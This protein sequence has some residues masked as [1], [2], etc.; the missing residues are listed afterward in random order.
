VRR[1]PGWRRS[2]GARTISGPLA[3][4]PRA[5]RAR[6][7]LLAAGLGAALFLLAAR[8][9]HLQ[10]VRAGDLG[11]LARSQQ[12]RTITLDPRRAPILDRNGKELALSVDVDSIFADPAEVADPATAARRL[13]PVLGLKPAELRERLGGDRHFVWIKRKVGPDLRRRVEALRIEGIGFVKE[14]RRF[15]PKRGLA[16]HVLGACGLDN[17]GLAGL[18]FAYDGAIQGTP[19]R[20][21]FLRDGRGGR[22]LDRSRTEPTPGTGLVLTIDEVLQHLAERELDAAMESFRPAGA[23]IVVLRPQSGEILALANR[24]TFDPNDFSSAREEARRD[25]AVTDYYEPGSTFKVITASAALDAKRVRPDETIWCENGS[26]VVARHRFKEDRVPYGNLTVTEVLAKS[27][28]VGAIKIASRLR[29]SE[30]LATIRAFGFGHK[31]GVELPGE[32]GGMLR[33]LDDWSGLSQ[34]SIAMG[35]E[36]GATPLQLAAALGALANDGVYVRPR[37]VG[38]T[39]APD[40][41]RIPALSA[42]PGETRRVIEESTARTLRRMLQ[43]VTVDGTGRAA[44]VPGYSVGGKTG[45]AQKIEGG[46]YSHQK[47][48]SWF[49]G[50]VPADRPALTIV[51]MVDEP[52]GPKFHGGDVA[53][54]VFSRV[55][56][57]ALEYLGVP[58]DVER[59]LVPDPPVVRAAF[60]PEQEVRAAG[61]TGRPSFTALAVLPAVVQPDPDGAAPG[62]DDDAMP[63]LRGLSLRQASE[64]LAARG[65]NCRVLLS[66]PRVT[67]QE[68]DPGAPLPR[69]G[70]C[71]ITY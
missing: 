9:A 63:D 21:E 29:A 8:C 61:G 25:R 4:T 55:A 18:E 41:R 69:A 51:V 2:R 66:G 26:I 65:L 20:I 53:A 28:N 15:Y 35:Q 64:A 46:H 71:T 50:F 48:V 70:R 16:A 37:I 52:R 59:P 38:E 11:D 1:R 45:T 7:V 33:D 32:S 30:F 40:G 17:Q 58:P 19:G 47:F 67:G 57:P 54:P 5:R 6:L 24:P 44:Q 43:S 31:T 22:V 13:A 14:S 42:A 62:A 10:F 60:R 12:E 49:A 3:P 39:I 36:I 27:S 23:A 34:A 68:P 56:L